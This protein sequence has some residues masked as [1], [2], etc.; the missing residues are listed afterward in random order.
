MNDELD[1]IKWIGTVKFIIDAK[2]LFHIRK[3]KFK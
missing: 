1:I 3:V 2:L